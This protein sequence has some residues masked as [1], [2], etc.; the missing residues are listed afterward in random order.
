MIFLFAASLAVN[1][2]ADDEA[3]FM[4]LMFGFGWLTTSNMAVGEPD[5]AWKELQEIDP[6]AADFVGSF[7]YTKCMMEH[8]AYFSSEAEALKL[9]IDHKKPDFDKLKKQAVSLRG[10]ILQCYL[11]DHAA[12]IKSMIEMRVGAAKSGESTTLKNTRSENAPDKQPTKE[13]ELPK[14]IKNP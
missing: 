3:E 8:H 13:P 1:A 14:A 6:L 9:G 10:R 5:H 11:Y 2:S 4:R 12:E 7:W